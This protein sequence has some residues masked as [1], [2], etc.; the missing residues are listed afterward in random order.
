VDRLISV[1]N[2][3]GSRVEVKVRIHRAGAATQGARLGV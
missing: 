1:L 3:L 2:R